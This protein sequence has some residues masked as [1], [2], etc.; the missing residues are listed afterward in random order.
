MAKYHARVPLTD[1]LIPDRL[2]PLDEA[3]AKSLAVSIKRRGLLHPITLRKTPPAT[4]GFK[5][6]IL[7]AGYHRLRAHEILGLQEISGFEFDADGASAQILEIEENLHR[8]DLSPIDRAIF[9][10]KRREL[11]EQQYGEIKRGGAK[12]KRISLWSDELG[13]IADRIGLSERMLKRAD[14]IGRDLTPELRDAIR[15]TPMAYNEGLLYRLARTEPAK[16]RVAAARIAE[17]KPIDTEVR[18]LTGKSAPKSPYLKSLNAA[19]GAF[20][21]LSLKEQR[22]LAQNLLAEYA[23]IFDWAL[24]H[25]RSNKGDAQ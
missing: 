3:H 14:K 4:K 10:Q 2:R 13:E 11:H 5:P 16:Q 6:W 18:E 23:A 19:Y 7:T 22:A 12:G 17:G 9:V 1:I 8:Y 21:R 15:A 20:C 24:K 25:P